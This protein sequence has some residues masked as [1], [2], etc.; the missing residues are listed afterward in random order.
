[1]PVTIGTSTVGYAARNPR[2][3]KVI[4]GAGR[5]WAWYCSGS[6]VGYCS[7][8][9]EVNF[10]AFTSVGSGTTGER[11]AVTQWTSGTDEKVAYV[12]TTSTSVRFRQGTLNSDGTITWDTASEQTVVSGLSAV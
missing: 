9:D 7:S 10:N 3:T 11:I 6:Y 12:R 1:M 8:S 5:V 4:R 2:L